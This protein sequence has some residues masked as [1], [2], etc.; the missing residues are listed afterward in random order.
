[1]ELSGPVKDKQRRGLTLLA[2]LQRKLGDW[3]IDVIVLDPRSPRQPIHREA[4]RTAEPVCSPN[5]S[6]AEP[7]LATLRIVHKESEHLEWSRQRLFNE[8]IDPR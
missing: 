3:P 8:S 2:R 4:Q 6:P 7:L 5:R 1:M